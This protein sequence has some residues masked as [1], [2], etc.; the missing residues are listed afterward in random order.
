MPEPSISSQAADST[1]MQTGADERAHDSHASASNAPNGHVLPGRCALIICAAR[2]CTL[3]AMSRELDAQVA[4]L[5]APPDPSRQAAYF[6]QARSRLRTP[7]A[8]LRQHA[9]ATQPP[10]AQLLERGGW[11]LEVRADAGGG[12]GKGLFATRARPSPAPRPLGKRCAAV[13]RARPRPGRRTSRRAIKSSQRRRW[14][15]RSTPPTRPWRAC[16]A[17]AC[18]TWARWRPSSRCAY[19]PAATRQA[20][21]APYAAG[22]AG[23]A[24]CRA[25]E[26]QPPHAAAMLPPL[27]YM[28][29]GCAGRGPAERWSRPAPRC[30]ILKRLWSGAGAYLDTERL[31]RLASGAERL[32]HSDRFPLAT[33]VRPAPMPWASQWR[34][35]RAV[36]RHRCSG[37]LEGAAPL[38]G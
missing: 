8:D 21:P 10:A 4:A 1:S 20:R 34:R 17:A 23:A 27:G 25:A 35:R 22:A 11:A 32:P 15:R 6:A 13:H 38:A 19:C 26:E 14:W 9:D 16:A 7:A 12:R 30:F 2:A 5:L 28:V 33:S 3:H 18:A 36:R 37:V 24:G 29:P 31:R